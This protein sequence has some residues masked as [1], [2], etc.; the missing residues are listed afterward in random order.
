MQLFCPPP[1]RTH[2][3]LIKLFLKISDSKTLKTIPLE[4]TGCLRNF[5]YLLAPQA[6]SF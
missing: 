3:I 6:S 5:Y 1:P 2:K 4:E